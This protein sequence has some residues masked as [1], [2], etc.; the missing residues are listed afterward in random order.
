MRPELAGRSATPTSF[1]FG[2]LAGSL[3]TTWADGY[4]S[5]ATI[6]VRLPDPETAIRTCLPPDDETVTLQRIRNTNLFEIVVSNPTDARA[7][8]DRANALAVKVEQAFNGGRIVIVRIW[9]KAE[10][11]VEKSP[12]R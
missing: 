4:Y 11:A 9:E 7:A 2:F 10:P 3:A 8:A 1:Y 12:Q 6:E 5:K